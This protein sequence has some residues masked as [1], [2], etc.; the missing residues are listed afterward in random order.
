MPTK[1]RFVKGTN[2]ATKD[3]AY[4]SALMGDAQALFVQDSIFYALPDHDYWMSKWIIVKGGSYLIKGAGKSIAD[5]RIDGQSVGRFNVDREQPYPIVALAPGPHR[6]DLVYLTNNKEMP[7]AWAMFGMFRGTEQIPE[8]YSLPS[9][10]VTAP[11]DGEPEL[12]S[13]PN[14]TPDMNLPVWLPRPDWKDGVR[15]T[16]EFMT[17]ILTSESEAE[18]RRSLRS[19]PRLIIES[20][21]TEFYTGRQV[22]DSAITALGRNDQLIPVPWVINR[23]VAD[24][25]VGDRSI[26]GDFAGLPEYFQGGL[27]I[28][29]MGEFQHEIVAISEVSDDTLLLGYP[30]RAP[31]PKGTELRPLWKGRIVDVQGAEFPIRHA[32]MFTV[33]WEIASQ[34]Y[35][36]PTWGNAQVYNNTGLPVLKELSDAHNWR[37]G[38]Q[39]DYNRQVW[40]HDNKVGKSIAVDIGKNTTQTSRIALMLQGRTERMAFLQL[41]YAAAGQFRTFHFPSQTDDMYL[42]ED[43]AADNGYIAIQSNGYSYYD[44]VSQDIRS[45]V[46]IEFFGGRHIMAHVIST[47]SIGGIDYLYL[48]HTIGDIA[49]KGV[50]RVRWCPYARMASDSVTIQYH[51]DVTGVS[52]TTLVVRSFFDRRKT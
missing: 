10:W 14:P 49:K 35:V 27:A 31:W 44:V 37:E 43:I 21:F 32:Q 11:G 3:I 20:K 45:W 18:Q 46:M 5:I 9:D 47:R 28:L 12:G 2:S 4:H 36:K 42:A 33:R 52:E 38:G 22:V 25:A 1:I 7:E 19:F 26:K 41:F 30:L 51:T 50:K 40:I 29:R 8:L 39:S 6:L 13:P 34:P 15:Q 23:T 17:D 24:L 16:I 48:D